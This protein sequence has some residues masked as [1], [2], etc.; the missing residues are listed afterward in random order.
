M[1]SGSASWRACCASRARTSRA[2]AAEDALSTA[3]EDGISRPPAL[4]RA[5]THAPRP[6]AARAS[7]RSCA[8]AR[9]EGTAVDRLGRAAAAR[10][11]DPAAPRAV[12]ADLENGVTSLWLARRR[13]RPAGRRPGRR[14]STA[15]TSTSPRSSLDAGAE[16][17]GRRRAL[18]RLYDGARRRPGRRRAAPSAPT[19]SGCE[20]R[21]GAA[22]G[23][24]RGRRRWRA[25]CAEDYPRLRA[26]TVDALPYHDAGG[27]RRRRSWAARWRPGSPTCGR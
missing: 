7:P 12:L 16:T 13:R 25:R 3:L 1:S 26:V 8:A 5:T 9:A 27:S 10:A 22:P 4:H 2:T 24:R 19:R 15:S 20:A 18:L 11:P 17:R 23:P 6:P 14:R 21:T